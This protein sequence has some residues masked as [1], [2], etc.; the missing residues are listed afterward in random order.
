ME[1]RWA[2]RKQMQPGTRDT[3][4]EKHGCMVPVLQY[5]RYYGKN[6]YSKFKKRKFPIWLYCV[7]GAKIAI[8]T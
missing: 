1:A 8:L 7:F 2:G 3:P 5:G 6:A 4:G